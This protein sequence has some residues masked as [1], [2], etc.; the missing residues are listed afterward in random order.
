[1][2]S[3][4]KLIIE[5]AENEI[6]VAEILE[7]LSKE[8]PNINSALNIPSGNTFYSSVISHSYYSIFYGAKAYLSLKGNK[9]PEQGQHKAVYQKFKKLVKSGELDKEL[10]IIYE[11]AKLKAETLLSIFEDEGD[12]RAT[13][14]YKTLPQANMEPAHKSIENAKFFVSHI[15]NMLK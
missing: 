5:R 7:K 1:M 6:L 9:I 12:K 4:V 11:D 13:F 14:T 15:K 2:D 10:L 3:E 8:N